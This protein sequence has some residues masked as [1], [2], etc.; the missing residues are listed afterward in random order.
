MEEMQEALR[1]KD[2]FSDSCVLSV[3]ACTFSN[4]SLDE[5]FTGDD[6]SSQR[7]SSTIVSEFSSTKTLMNIDDSSARGSVREFF[8]NQYSNE[9]QDE[10]E[11]KPLQPVDKTPQI[12]HLHHSFEVKDSW[13]RS[14]TMPRVESGSSKKRQTFS[15]SASQLHSTKPQFNVQETMS[16]E[17]V[18][19]KVKKSD[20][21]SKRV[22]QRREISSSQRVP[23][24]DRNIVKK[25]NNDDHDER[26]NV[27]KRKSSPKPKSPRRN[28]D[29]FRS[30]SQ[31]PSPTR[32]KR[33][34]M[35]DV[36]TEKTKSVSTT[37]MKKLLQNDSSSHDQKKNKKTDLLEVPKFTKEKPKQKKKIVLDFGEFPPPKSERRVQTSNASSSEEDFDYSLTQ[38]S[39]SVQHQSNNF[40]LSPIEENSEASTSG[41]S[42]DKFSLK[43]LKS[44]K[45]AFADSPK[46]SKEFA[47]SL[48]F[49]ASRKY[50]TYPKSRI[51]VPR[52]LG[53][54]REFRN[55]MDPKLYPL[56]PR[57]VD[58]EAFQ[59]LHTADSQEEL[60]EFLLLESQCSGNLGLATNFSN[61]EISDH[62][63]DDERGTMSGI[64]LVLMHLKNFN[65]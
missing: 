18:L 6:G 45:V 60:Q 32:T 23:L 10:M 42:Q 48:E 38:H 56:E 50:H 7:D 5:H 15:K 62:H 36:T 22:D 13:L 21:K 29:E 8:L 24:R 14:T 16:S 52:K 58:L 59:Q 37:G 2:E 34:R 65:I 55:L 44:K 51:P 61:S 30:K 11:Y 41:S 54:N 33:P 39:H 4:D 17:P 47:F 12:D 3:S 20:S 9:C 35:T 63:S 27:V 46:S 19:Q 49:D 28:L 31:S 53:N 40:Y 64:Y 26:R 1:G 57:E 25:T 43:Q